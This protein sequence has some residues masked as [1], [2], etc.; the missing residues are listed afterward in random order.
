M[1]KERE[2]LGNRG[3]RHIWGQ[4]PTRVELEQVFEE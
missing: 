3:V 1:R 4:S 2:M